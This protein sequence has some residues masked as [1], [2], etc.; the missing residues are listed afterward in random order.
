[1]AGIIAENVKD[2]DLSD[3]RLIISH[4]CCEERA[5]NLLEKITAGAPFG[6]TEIVKCSGLNS[7]YAANGG[8]IVSY[9]K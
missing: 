3:K 5:K 1:M 9:T 2:T 7:T 8:I 4:V 6:S